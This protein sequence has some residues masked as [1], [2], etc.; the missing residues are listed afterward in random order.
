MFLHDYLL[1]ITTVRTLTLINLNILEN[2]NSVLNALCQ[3]KGHCSPPLHAALYYCT[4][5]SNTDVTCV[6]SAIYFISCDPVS[7]NQMT[8]IYIA[9]I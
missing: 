9:V 3:V 4:V 2:D 6:Q 7:S 1:E 8:R 5:L